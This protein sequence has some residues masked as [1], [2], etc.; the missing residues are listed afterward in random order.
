MYNVGPGQ[1]PIVCM[2]RPHAFV[3]CM[4]VRVLTVDVHT[5]IHVK[6]NS[7]NE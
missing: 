3:A 2:H 5:H 7:N 6:L 4:R 1:G